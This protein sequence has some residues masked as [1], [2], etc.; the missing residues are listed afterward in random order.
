MI[1][2]LII[3]NINSRDFQYRAIILQNDQSPTA[4][5]QPVAIAVD[6]DRGLL[7]WLDQ[8]KGGVSAK[9]ARADIGEWHGDEIF[10]NKILLPRK[11]TKK[12][13]FEL[14]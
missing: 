8:G 2:F 14:M 4:V 12:W 9:V 13:I 3:Y 5:S 1:I 10:L 6:S 11:I 7:F